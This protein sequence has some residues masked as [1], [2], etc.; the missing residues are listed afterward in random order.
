MSAPGR[1]GAPRKGQGMG[2]RIF[3]GAAVLVFAV[4][5]CGDNG[6]EG[7]AGAAASP[8]ARK[9]VERFE[10]LPEGPWTTLARQLVET[11]DLESA[12][13]TTREVLARGGIATLGDATPLVPAQGPASSFAA[14][15]LE[16]VHLAMEARRK[17]TAGRL[18]GAE[19]AQMLEAFGW[20]FP[21]ARPDG[22]ADRPLVGGPS[23]DDARVIGED[24]ASTRQQARD[25]RL[26]ARDAARDAMDAKRDAAL[27]EFEA[28][29]TAARAAHKAAAVAHAAT[30]PADRAG[31]MARMRAALDEVRVADKAWNEARTAFQATETAWREEGRAA[32]ELARVEEGIAR[33]I[34]PD[35][36]NGERF[37]AFLA[38]WVSEAAKH[39]E[40]PRSFTPLFLAEMARLQAAPVDLFGAKRV[41]PL[42][43]DP[44]PM[45]GAP[46]AAQLKW[47]LL[48][49]QLFAAAFHRS[50]AAPPHAASTIADFLIPAAHAEG[51]CSDL[52]AS[53]GPDLGEIHATASA[54]TIGYVLDGALGAIGAAGEAI[55]N[56]LSATAIV[57]KVIKLAAFYSENQ[58]TVAAEPKFVHKPTG[59]T[60]L[61]TYTAT[62]GVSPAEL[63]EYRRLAGKM[64]RADQS[65]RDCL[66]WAGF[67][68]LADIEDVAKDAETW[69]IDWSIIEGRGHAY[70]SLAN[71]DLYIKGVRQ[72]TKMKRVSDSSAQA[73]FV[74]DIL[75]ESAHTG[76]TRTAWV[77]VRAEV[78]AAGMPGLGTLI[79]AGKGI[80]GLADSL[81][82]IAS[83]WIMVMF[84]PKA[85]ATVLVEYHCARPTTV[86][87]YVKDSVSDGEGDDG[88]PCTWVFDT[89]DDFD[90]WQ[91]QGD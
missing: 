56:A 26:A 63:Q 60:K 69:L 49:M 67:P 9:A 85:E 25:A 50:D 14:T 70:W 71:N 46:R 45:R 22:A 47:T 55:G 54:E 79:N 83:G 21:D 20:P 6:A 43:D 89:K 90:K 41:S 74:V 42:D 1:R 27:G 75:S 29:R 19:F 16:T 12:V 73:K 7:A 52:K 86:H 24:D 76:R 8:Q 87:R 65:V 13:D 57:G 62:A 82:D 48:E 72:A 66:G 10:S 38:A 39:P 31:S 61:V 28:R 81:A 11:Q 40:D 15:P 51:P 84:K 18:T 44:P 36:A 30:P 64:S 53:M 80:L 59:G 33:R 58:V 4:G 34:G 2:I 91:A 5:A 35:Y 37:M 32:A 78:D 23:P 68:S 77:T 17:A 88:D 3:L